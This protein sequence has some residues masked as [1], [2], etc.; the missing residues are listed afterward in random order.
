MSSTL[1]VEPANRRK[2]SLSTELK[3]VL[4]KKY[5]G[6][7]YNKL[8]DLSDLPYLQA[9]V[10]SGVEGAQELIDYIGKYDEVILNEEF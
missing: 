6:V 4:Q 8:M 3:F 10:D 1:K 9:L 5:K 2:K 7:I